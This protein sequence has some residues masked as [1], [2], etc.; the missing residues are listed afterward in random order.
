MQTGTPDCRK[1][2]VGEAL[3]NRARDVYKR[4]VQNERGGLHRQHSGNGHA[5]LLSAGKLKGRFS[6]QIFRKAD[7]RA[8]VPHALGDLLFRQSEILRPKGHVFFHGF[9]K[10][11]IFRILKDQSDFA[12]DFDQA[13]VFFAHV[14]AAD[15]DMPDFRAHQGVH[16]RD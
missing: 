14:H 10:E 13:L 7:L 8:S 5:A 9:L 1:S 4:Q 3:P 6:E 15:Q 11:L 2:S 12:P 16:M